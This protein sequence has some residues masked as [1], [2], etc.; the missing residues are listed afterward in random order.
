MRQLRQQEVKEIV[1]ILQECLIGK[2]SHGIGAQ[3][4]IHLFRRRGQDLIYGGHLLAADVFHKALHELLGAR[5]QISGVFRV[6][7]AAGIFLEA[8]RQRI[9][10]EQRIV[11]VAHIHTARLRQ[12][13]Q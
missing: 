12:R 2:R 11:K 1:V 5:A 13:H 7:D 3:Q 8:P 9:A 6:G 10:D 4:N